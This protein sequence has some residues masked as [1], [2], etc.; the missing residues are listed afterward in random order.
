[1][2]RPIMAVFGF[3]HLSL[4]TLSLTAF[5]LATSCLAMVAVATS[6]SNAIAQKKAAATKEGQVQSTVKDIM[7]A[8]V[9]PSADAIWGAVGTV[10]DE[11]GVHESA[12]KSDDDWANMRRAAI[13]IIEGGNLLAMPGREVAPPGTKSETPGVELEPAEIA[14]IIKSKRRSFD[15]FA[16]ALRGLGFEVLAASEKK[17]AASLIEIGGRMQDVCENCHQTFWYPNAAQPG[18][19]RAPGRR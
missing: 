11:T 12:P 15:A 8:I 13:R 4:A 3:R 16:R 17:D 9:D 7:D 5:C 2:K 6:S 18:S 14:V 10:V 1:M 19:N